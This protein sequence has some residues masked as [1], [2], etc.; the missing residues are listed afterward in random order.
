MGA[1]LYLMRKTDRGLYMDQI[2]TDVS[3]L[4]FMTVIS[5]FFNGLLLTQFDSYDIF[6]K[7][8]IS[9]L[10]ISTFGFLFATLILGNTTQEIIDGK[11]EKAKKHMLY[12]YAISEYIGV[13]LFVLSIT[14]AINIITPD[15][16]LR[17][18]TLF[19]ALGGIALYQFMGFSM[20]NN[21]FPKTYTAFSI[22]TLGFGIALFAAQIWR[23]HF[24]EA[25]LAFLVFILL[26]TILAP[27]KDFE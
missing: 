26:I 17:I 5:V 23:F 8:P 19:A 16:Y 21:H 15:I 27:R 3:L 13:Y 25:S 11:I 14:L 7:I 20:L 1:I 6:I 24:T 22:L 9:F 2:Q 10:I 18:I 12:G 4:S